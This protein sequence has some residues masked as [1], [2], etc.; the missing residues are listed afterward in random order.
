MPGIKFRHRGIFMLLFIDENT[1]H[2]AR[3]L[4]GSVLKKTFNHSRE[5]CKVREDANNASPR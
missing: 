2:I 1:M 5:A 3:I 4:R